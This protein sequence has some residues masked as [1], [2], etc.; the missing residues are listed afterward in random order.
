MADHKIYR[1]IVQAVEGGRLQE[2]F[3]TFEFQASCPGLGQGTYQAFL[4]KHRRGNPGGNS[5]L[6]EQVA[7][8]R[9]VL[10]RPLKYGL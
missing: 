7:P 4:Y 5:E 1:A 2:P 8:G 3:G 9:F 10:M 6:F